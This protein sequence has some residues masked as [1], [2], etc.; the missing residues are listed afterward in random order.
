MSIGK[1]YTHAELEE[2]FGVGFVHSYFE[3]KIKQV[4]RHD[5]EYSDVFDTAEDVRQSLIDEARTTYCNRMK[6]LWDAVEKYDN[7]PIHRKLFSF[8]FREGWKKDK[9]IKDFSEDRLEE[10]NKAICDAEACTV[11]MLDTEAVYSMFTPELVVGQE[12]Y[13]S[14]TRNDYLDMG[15]HVA[16]V[17]DIRWYVNV[18]KKT[19]SYEGRLDVG[20]EELSLVPQGNEGKLKT[21]YAFHEVHLNIREAIER[22]EKHI[23]K[24][25]TDFEEV[26]RIL[27]EMK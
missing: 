9:I 12:V 23:N 11:E 16:T 7:L 4:F 5:G 17:S 26:K 18:D 6:Q 1:R 25:I 22:V 21:G 15:V 20:G 10:L 3:G 27:G 2:K 24:V 14:V 13:I 19:V 8:F